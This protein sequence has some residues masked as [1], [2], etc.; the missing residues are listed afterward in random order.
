MNQASDQGVIDG[1]SS[2][3][4]SRIV[5]ALASLWRANRYS[6][7]LSC[8]AWDFAVE[9][10]SMRRIG[11]DNSDL[12][13]LACAGLVEHAREVTLFG[14]EGRNFQPGGTL[15][16]SS[17]TCFILS[18]KGVQEASRLFGN[19]VADV[20]TVA[21]SIVINRRVVVGGVRGNGNGDVRGSGNGYVRGNGDVKPV[22]DRE[23]QELRVEDVLVKAFK[24]P[25]PN[26]ETVINAFDEEGWPTRIDDPLPPRGDVDPKRRLH[27]TIKSLNRNQKHR[28]LRFT[29][30]GTGEGIRWELFEPAVVDDHLCKAQ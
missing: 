3:T 16:F 18:E 4:N 2:S 30:D 20:P 14:E 24:L 21:E 8:N 9:I 13:W 7:E 19:P 10:S 12:R 25:S 27:D 29:G 5:K 15:A 26:Q 11:V 28:M 17:R 1:F 6:A 22:W 23:R